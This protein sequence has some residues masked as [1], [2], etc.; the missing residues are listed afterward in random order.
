MP[1]TTKEVRPSFLAFREQT[2]MALA[3]WNEEELL[4]FIVDNNQSEWKLFRVGEELQVK[5]S[6]EPV[7][8]G[9]L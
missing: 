1:V 4:G 7:I 5:T 3:F 2:G 9:D 8:T 6:I